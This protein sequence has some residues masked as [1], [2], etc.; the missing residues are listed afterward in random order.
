MTAPDP[1]AAKSTDLINWIVTRGLEGADKE[2]LLDGYCTRLV[3][4]GVPLMRFHAAQSALHPVYGGTGYSWYQGRG[5]DYQKFKYSEDVSEDWQNSPLFAILNDDIDFVHERIVDQNEPSKYPLINELREVGA[6]DYYAT[7]VAFDVP[8]HNMPPDAKKAVDGVLLSWTSNAPEGFRDSDLEL[9]HTALP[10]LGLALKSAS[11]AR[12][13]KD[14]MRVYLGRDAG[15]R[16]LSGEIRRGSLQ[17][18]DA[19]IWNFDL[20]GFTSLSEELPGNEIIDMLNDYL[21]VAVGVV[22][23]NDGNILKFMGDGLMAMFDVGDIDADARA[24]L[25][26]VPMLQS[27]IEE[28]NAAREADGLPVANY[29]LALHSGEILY[30]NIGSESRLDFT[31]IGPAVN[32][33]ARIAGMHRS[34]GQRILISD[35]VA[36]AAQPCGKELISVGR[37]MLRGVPEPKELFTVYR[38]GD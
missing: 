30:G 1:N 3:E 33:T 23:D 22:H 2:E 4:L 19:V 17:Q 36:R 35:D 12:V 26:A 5:G 13:S 15:R 18:I 7:S 31:V 14:L 16:V 10:H 27:R 6:T 38:P 32:Q 11:N 28:L 21:A 29:T 9:I 37:Y 34:L 24:A 25:K 20:E 8:T